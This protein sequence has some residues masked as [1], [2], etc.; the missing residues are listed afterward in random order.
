M[1]YWHTLLGTSRWPPI[2]TWLRNFF[3]LKSSDEK[4]QIISP[5]AQISAVQTDQPLFDS[6]VH[7]Y[8]RDILNYLW[9]L[10]ASAQS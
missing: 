9:R 1:A 5:S 4:R 10:T 8:E 7:R 6:F 3:A 2:Q